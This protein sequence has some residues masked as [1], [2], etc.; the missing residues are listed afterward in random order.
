LARGEARFPAIPF[1]KTG[2]GLLLVP[3]LAIGCRGQLARDGTRAPEAPDRRR[4]APRAL[5]RH[6]PGLAAGRN[7]IDT[8]PDQGTP[9]VAPPM[10]KAPPLSS[11]GVKDKDDSRRLA[12][13]ANLEKG[14][15]NK[16]KCLAPKA[17]AVAP[18]AHPARGRK[19][20]WDYVSDCRV[21]L[22]TESRAVTL[23]IR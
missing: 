23:S 14:A 20:L 21:G 2:V 5:D 8:F 7:P 6:F 17:N 16:A 13:A 15:K 19:G 12:L 1:F 3:G 11:V 22:A 9:P 10:L 18:S 4:D